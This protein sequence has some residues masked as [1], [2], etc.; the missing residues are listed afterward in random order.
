MLNQRE[1]GK[2]PSQPMVNP[3]NLEQVQAITY[4]RKDK[5]SNNKACTDV[6]SSD[7]LAHDDKIEKEVTNHKQPHG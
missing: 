3:R 7:F 5:A 4:F 6:L 1:L 2:F